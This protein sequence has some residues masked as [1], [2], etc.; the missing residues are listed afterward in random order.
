MKTEPHPGV[1]FW[2]GI[3]GP[4][5]TDDER[6]WLRELEPAGILLFQRN[7]HDLDQLIAL[8][9]ELKTKLIHVPVLAV[10]QEGGL[11]QRLQPVLPSLPPADWWTGRE[12]A[13]R[14][15]MGALARCMQ[16]L[17][18]SMNLFPVVDL[19]IQGSVL[20][21]EH[22]T[23]H[24]SP[25]I[26]TRRARTC[27]QVFSEAGVMTCLKHFP[28]LGRGSFDTHSH[29]CRIQT[30]F[31]IF[32]REDLMPF[33]RLGR[34]V[35]AV[36]MSHAEYSGMAPSSGIPA[37]LDE[38]MYRLLRKQCGVRT[39]AL[40][41][42]LNMKALSQRWSALEASRIALSS[43]ADGVL[44]CHHQFSAELTYES[45]RLARAHGHLEK[46][47]HKTWKRVQYW[48]ERFH[49]TIGKLPDKKGFLKA[50]DLLYQSLASA[51]WQL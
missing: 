49:Q 18:L 39:L 19:G 36:M 17:G 29:R 33:R 23:F 47:L 27:I 4:E 46:R 30:S 1:W 16:Q 20:T 13:L 8:I 7:I 9:I 43:G 12:S 24:R 44:I 11:V 5:L 51:G 35:P 28:G 42:D 50:R 37:S 32:F 34:S 3:E 21:Q 2:V 6:E 25:R 40:T 41:D 38:N 22:R 31:D 15:V 14:S 48:R 26:V 10:D 45:L